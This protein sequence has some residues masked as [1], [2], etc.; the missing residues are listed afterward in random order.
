LPIALSL[1]GCGPGVVW[2]GKSPDRAHAA[3]VE[4]DGRTQRLKLDGVPGKPYLGVGV[5][6]IAWSPDG[7][8]LAY[9]AHVAGGWV[10]VEGGKEGP[11]ENGIGEIVWSADSK[12]LAYAAER[13]GRWLVVKDGREGP[14][15]EALRA[16][17][18]KLSDDGEHFA[19]AGDEGGKVVAVVDGVRSAP[20][21]GVGHLVLAPGGRCA[22]VARAGGKARIV[23]D[24][25]ESAA[26]EDIADLAFSPSGKKLAWTARKGGA[27]WVVEGASESGPFER[28]SSLVWAPRGE[29]L[30]FA[31]GRAGSERVMSG[32]ALG[33][34]YDG[35][36]PGSLSFDAS[37]GHV[38]YAARRRGAW[39][40]VADGEE[41][42][43]FD[44]VEMPRFVG[45]SSAVAHLARRGEAT[46]VVLDGHFG[47]VVA[48]ATELVISPDGMRFLHAARAGR[49]TAVIEGVA[50]GAP[51]GE[52]RCRPV[53]T[54]VTLQDAVIGGTLVLGE[55]GHSGY[56]AGREADRSLFVVID[57][58]K[59]G[60][61]DMAELMSGLVVTP[62][63]AGALT[64]DSKV[65]AQW[66]RAEV[67][68][69]ERRAAA[70]KGV[71]AAPGKDESPGR[72]AR[73][74]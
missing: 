27:W 30:A 21:D 17:S 65:L 40:V 28:V 37:G 45:D 48:D 46:F 29:S 25:K 73:M 62:D 13:H 19:Y 31:V 51:C 74:P 66:V 9:P 5:E 64:G 4:Q 54:R 36:L 3:A 24:G 34:E 41:S 61:L 71:V 33:P 15:L 69:A 47:P 44:D 20:Y 32:G 50:A 16:H 63:L 42:P 70:A 23:A 38:V 12:H 60:A 68:L 14:T 22:F 11:V 43:P 56:V 39:V 26:Y 35:V 10:V 49:A 58:A 52:G 7:T 1:A 72:G 67:A 57:G 8:R 55:G 18:L 6:A 53:S 2:F 59:A